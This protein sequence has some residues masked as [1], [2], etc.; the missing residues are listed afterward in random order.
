[1]QIPTNIPSSF[2]F[3][4]LRSIIIDGRESVVTAIIN[5]RTTPSKAPFASRASAIRIVPNISAYMGT[6]AIAA[7]ITRYANSRAS[8]FGQVST[9]RLAAKIPVTDARRRLNNKMPKGD[10]FLAKRL[11]RFGF[12]SHQSNITLAMVEPS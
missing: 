11:P 6:P 8:Y 1:M 3:T 7:A 2:G 5:D 4:A 9:N 12:K 10:G